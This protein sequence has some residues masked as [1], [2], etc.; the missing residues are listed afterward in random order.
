M[1]VLEGQKNNENEGNSYMDNLKTILK[2]IKENNFMVPE[3]LDVNELVLRMMNNIGDSDP[4]LRDKL[5]YSTMSRWVMNNEI[6]IENLKKML[7]MSINDNHLFFRIGEK[8]T[9]SV[10]TRSFSILLIPLILIKHRESNFLSKEEIKEVYTKVVDYFIK[11]KDLRGYV[12][13]KGWAHSVAH[14]ADALDDLALCSEIEYRELVNILEIIKEKVCISSYVYINEEDERLV[15]AVM[16][17]LNRGLIT[18][19][20]FCKWIRSFNKYEKTGSYPE[21]DNILTN[22]KSFLRSLYFRIIKREYKRRLVDEIK[23]SL[24]GISNFN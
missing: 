6:S 21:D 11:E 13:D 17:I 10:F 8:D 19:E 12:M 3:S 23:T 4:E 18:D 22:T 16:N 1:E 5:I 24:E 14:A 7:K 2:E 9:D 20:E 15:T